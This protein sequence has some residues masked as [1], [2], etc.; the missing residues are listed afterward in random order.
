MFIE[1]DVNIG[2]KQ[3]EGLERNEVTSSVFLQ[4]KYGKILQGFSV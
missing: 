2:L 3:P 4:E 1:G